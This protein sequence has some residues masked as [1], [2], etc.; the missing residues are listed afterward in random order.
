MSNVFV[1]DT[2]KKPLDPV[3]P[4]EA[5]R[6]L[7][8]GKAA[9]W[10]RFP[11]TII[12]KS[13]GRTST[14][15]PLRIK[16]DP[17][18]KTTGIAIVNDASGEVVFAAELSHRGQA[19]KASLDDRRAVRR[20]RRQ[21]KTRYRKAR[22]A[23]RKR[24]PGWMPPSLESRIANIVT[25]VSRFSRYAP[26]QAISQE[27]VKFDMQLMENAE[28][29][30]VHYQQGT[31]QGYEI[32][33]YLLE[34][35][36]R[37][38]SYCGKK[39]I[40]LQIEH[41]HPRANGGTNRISNLCLACEKCNSAKDTRDIKDFLKKKPE[42]LKKI[43]AQAKSP[44]K[45]A[46]VVNVTRWALHE[47]VKATGLPVEC[48]SG[49]LTKF[50][51]TTRTLPKTHWIDAANVGRSTPADLI[52]KGVKPLVIKATGNGRRKMCVTDAYGFPKQ[53][54]E[55]KGFSMGYRTGDVVRAITPKGTYQGRIAIRH[56]PSFRL[57]KIDV[58]PKYMRRLHR[59]DGYE[60]VHERSASCSS[61]WVNR[62]VPASR[63]FKD[64]SQHGM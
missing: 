24:K 41:I 33:E 7:S 60:Y 19:I 4:G 50:N 55:R 63:D 57:G 10:R 39:D 12:L 56:R 53:H 25:W 20:S 44:L 46:A 49:G 17:G 8:Q 27:L 18:S 5:R 47:H 35:W 14:I 23:N 61:P 32:R 36:N 40:P 29:S 3:H 28:I 15:Q 26:I 48:G 37:T 6:L 58:H 62:G 54:K 51:R 1:V 59:V 42:V 13:E 30:G 38:C 45:D 52:I 31:L 43:L 64:G 11:F 34:K 9:V 21:R 16:L 2:N 22:W